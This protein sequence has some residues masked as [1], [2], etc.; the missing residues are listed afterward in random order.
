MTRT[1]YWH[2]AV[3]SPTAMYKRLVRAAI[4]ARRLATDQVA[5][6]TDD[7]LIYELMHEDASGLARRLRARR[8]AKRALDVFATELAAY[9][10]AGP[11]DDLVLQR[12]VEAG[13]PGE[14]VRG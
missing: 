5:V 6:A 10:P 4:A 3:R 1:V 14:V 13:V 12:R 9:T 8:L 2:N 7:G 11:S